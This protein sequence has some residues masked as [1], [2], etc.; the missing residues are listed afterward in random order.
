MKKRNTQ[1]PAEP[2]TKIHQ[3]LS[4]LRSQIIDGHYKPG[5]RF[6]TFD[7]MCEQFQVSR[8]VLQQAV[9][10]LR[11]DGFVKTVSR[12]GMY[13]SMHPPHLCRHAL[14]FPGN[15]NRLG[16]TR[17][18]KALLDAAE[19]VARNNPDRQYAVYPGA[20]EPES[21]SIVRRQ[22]MEDIRNRR[23]VGVIL[24]PGAMRFLETCPQIEEMDFPR[25][26]LGESSYW[27]T[28]PTVSADTVMFYRRALEALARQGRK[29]VAIIHM[30]GTSSEINHEELYAS[31]GLEY[32]ESWIQYVG[33]RSYPESI[34][35]LLLLLFDSCSTKCLDGLIIADD[36][37][38]DHAMAGLMRT[39]LRVGQDLDVIAYSHWPWRDPCVLPIRR[40]GF[41]IGEMMERSMNVLQNLHNGQPV[42]DAQLIPAVFEEELPP[43][44]RLS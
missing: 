36:N 32:H 21:N 33:R 42:P 30:A 37:L 34:Q 28:K 13:V 43:E 9:G 17:L 18:F 16:Y 8:A 4:G 7:E 35:H 23:L 3:V 20:L 10:T 1:L 26:F 19:G 22:V 40:L 31:A 5:Q 38:V 14:I 24:A 39:G 12:Q 25:V 11:R 2:T 29:H 44:A 41:D 6:P 27:G 15:E